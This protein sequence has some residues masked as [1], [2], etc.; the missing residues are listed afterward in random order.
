MKAVGSESP[1]E[2]PGA[3]SGAGNCR[4]RDHRIAKKAVHQIG[5]YA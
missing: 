1:I 4:L 2:A 3:R 5:V